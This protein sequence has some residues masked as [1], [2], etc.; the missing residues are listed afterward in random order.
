M[1]SFFKNSANR[2]KKLFTKTPPIDQ[3]PP[4][5]DYYQ[6]F[7]KGV[8]DYFGN[9]KK[10]EPGFL[11]KIDKYI[12]E[13]FSPKNTYSY[14]EY[15]PLT[16]LKNKIKNKLLNMKFKILIIFVIISS[17]YIIIFSFKEYIFCFKYPILI[18][19][20]FKLYKLLR[21]IKK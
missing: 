2:I 10:P 9:K 4:P 15:N 11:K 17:G 6:S 20:I 18:W 3:T 21:F 16:I 7:M 14:S 5:Q 1:K 13:K 8:N 12:N 19:L